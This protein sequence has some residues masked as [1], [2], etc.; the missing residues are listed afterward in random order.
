MARVMKMYDLKTVTKQKQTLGIGQRLIQSID[1]LQMTDWELSAYILA[2][3]EQNPALD[4]DA[5]YAEGSPV[6]FCEKVEWLYGQRRSE[7]YTH[8]EDADG[9]EPD[10]LVRLGAEDDVQNT[11]KWYLLSQLDADE[12]KGT[13]GKIY[14]FLVECTDKRG[15]LDVSASEA[16]ALLNVEERKVEHCLAV[17]RDLKPNG[18]C[19]KNLESCLLAQL[20]EIPDSETAEA[21]VKNHLT[22]FSKGYYSRISKALV[23]PVSEVLGACELIKTLSPT[24]AADILVEKRSTEYLVPDAIVT[25]TDGK[26]EVALCRSYMPYIAL[27]PY[28]LKLYRDTEDESVRQYLDGKFKAAELLIKNIGQRENT[29]LRCVSII[30]DV[31]SDYFSSGSGALTPMTLDDVAKLAGVHIS[32]VSRAIKGK[33]VQSDRGV[34]SLR[35]LFSKRLESS[36]ELDCSADMAQRYIAYFIESESKAAPLSDRRLCELLAVKGIDISRRT[37]AKYRERL[38]IPSTLCRRIR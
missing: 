29:F 28:Y 14:S 1:I 36:Y 31:Q 18:I 7:K 11:L 26:T 22:D 30:A 10:P 4:M 33:Y 3:A 8:A 16:A 9:D 5:L 6:K 38:G 2:E 15:Y 23:V 35:E 21:I 17:L 32:T 27:N 12:M 20:C 13:K 25:V 24:P 34:I 19:A 37:V